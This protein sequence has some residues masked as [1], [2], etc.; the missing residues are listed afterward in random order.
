MGLSL[1]GHK[2]FAAY[3]IYAPAFL[4]VAGL[5]LGVMGGQ[6]LTAQEEQDEQ[7]VEIEEPQENQ[8]PAEKQVIGAT[9]QV[10]EVS[11]GF[12]FPARVDTGAKSC[13]LHVERIEIKEESENRLDNIGKS[14]RFWVKSPDGKTEYIETLIASSV[15]IRNAQS[16]TRRYKVRLALQVG[17]H[18]KEVL[19]TLNDRDGMEYPVLLG[20]NFLRGDYI[21][22]VDVDNPEEKQE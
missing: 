6:R 15:I 10:T 2:Q 21:V 3:R 4:A 19:V 16:E 12:T 7:E 5:L 22:D 1:S 8:E 18:K 9:A 14:I 17:D 20:R 13:S 11:T